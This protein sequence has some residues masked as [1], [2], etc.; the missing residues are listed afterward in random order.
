[1]SFVSFVVAVGLSALAIGLRHSTSPAFLGLALSNLANLSNGLSNL[2]ISM[3]QSENGSVSIS[4]VHEISNLPPEEETASVVCVPAL[5]EKGSWP[6][7]GSIKFE[8]VQMRYKPNLEPALKGVSFSVPAGQRVGICGRTGSGKSSIIL[9]LF[10][11]LD[12]SL[13]SGKISIDD[14]DIQDLPI[15]QLRD[16]LSLVA[17]EPFLWHASLRDNLDPERQL[18]DRDIWSALQQVGMKEAVSALPD[19]IETHVEDGG[20]FSRGQ[21]Q[22]LCLARVLLRRRKIVILDEASSSLDLE[23]DEKMREVIRTELAGCTVIAVAHR[24][25]TIMDFD[26]ILVM[27]EGVVV[28]WGAPQEL[29]GRSSSRFAL[30]AGSQG[31]S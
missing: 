17:Q 26:M 28:E 7:E 16:S 18:Q 25:A 8:N 21:R 13:T 29:L 19:G 11:G 5:H 15:A 14:A 4:R 10:R 30:L 27:D 1:V 22:L 9:A 12:R 2:L 3:A 31:L 6:R 20:S 24:L 23:T